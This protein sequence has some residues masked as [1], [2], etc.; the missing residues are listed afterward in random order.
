MRL[1]PYE[2]FL[3]LDTDTYVAAELNEV[4]Q[5]LEHFDFAGHQLFE[6]HDSPIP[7]VPDAFPEFNGGV[8]AFRRSLAVE[9]FFD[10][11][12]E[13]YDAFRAPDRP[14]RDLYL[15]VTDQ[16]SLRLALYESKLRVA[17]LGPE[18]DFTPSHVNFACATVR[19]LH[20]RGDDFERF[21]SRL[22]AQL[23]NRVYHPTLDVVLHAQ[24]SA[25]EL[26]RLWWR[27]TVQLL[28]LLGVVCTPLRLR[29][30]LRRNET[31]RRLF[32]GG[33]FAP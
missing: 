22:N 3:Y 10:R 7:G 29:N 33:R 27:S 26:R 6:G 19:I 15:N 5:L 4:F 32:F 18:Y 9:G 25:P 12:R 31:V 30:R 2:K 20:G 13:L 21:A 16:K 14:D 8:L 28:R 1:C 11:W 17:I 23:G 24:T